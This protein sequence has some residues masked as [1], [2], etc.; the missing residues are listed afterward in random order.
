MMKIYNTPSAEI[1][2]LN[3]ADVITISAPDDL[4]DYDDTV[5]APNTWFN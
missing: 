1:V 2:E 3:I 4:A 5:N